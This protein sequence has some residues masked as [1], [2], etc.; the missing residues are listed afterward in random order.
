MVTRRAL[1]RPMTLSVLIARLTDLRE[2]HGGGVRVV[3]RKVEVDD[4]GKTVL[5]EPDPEVM[6]WPDDW[7][8]ADVY[9]P[10]AD[11]VGK[12]VVL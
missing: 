6:A 9:F 7:P 12:V 10:S 1:S 2:A 3:L 4:T 11:D 5:T 8:D